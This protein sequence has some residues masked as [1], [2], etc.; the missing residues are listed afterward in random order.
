MSASDVARQLVLEHGLPKAL[1]LT[2]SGR[3]KAKRQRSRKEYQY[4]VAVAF[5]IQSLSNESLPKLRH[6]WSVLT[7]SAQSNANAADQ[8]GE[9]FESGSATAVTDPLS[10][11]FSTNVAEGAKKRPSV[12]AQLDRTGDLGRRAARPTNYGASPA[13]LLGCNRGCAQ[14]IGAAPGKFMSKAAQRSQTTGACS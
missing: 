4:W 13:L 3:M 14:D 9:S 6:A 7:P 11:A 2:V 5:E 1:R 12:A 8:D 10:T